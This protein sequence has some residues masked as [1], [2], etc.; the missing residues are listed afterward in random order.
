MAQILWSGKH[1]SLR[2]LHRHYHLSAKQIMLQC[3][4]MLH[5]AYCLSYLLMLYPVW[6]V[7]KAEA[8]P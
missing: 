1:T 3:F 2:D 8:C 6:H 5:V 4:E 7:Q